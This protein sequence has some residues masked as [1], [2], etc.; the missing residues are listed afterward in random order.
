MSTTILHQESCWEGLALSHM[1]SW[2]PV[3]QTQHRGNKVRLY[4]FITQVLFYSLGILY[5]LCW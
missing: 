5:G 2:K 1:L 4:F 3:N